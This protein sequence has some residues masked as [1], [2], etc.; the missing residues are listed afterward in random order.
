MSSAFNFAAPKWAHKQ[1]APV[2]AGQTV[3]QKWAGNMKSRDT[4]SSIKESP[5]S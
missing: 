1:G 5:M 4:F 3:C 2:K